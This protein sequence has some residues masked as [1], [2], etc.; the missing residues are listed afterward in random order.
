M[1]DE[2]DHRER[3]GISRRN[4][5]AA[6]GALGSVAAGG[7]AFAAGHDDHS[8]HGSQRPELSSALAACAATGEI[9]VAHCLASFKSGDTTLADCATKVHEMLAVCSAMSTL[10]AGNSSHT[11]GLATVCVAVCEDCSAACRKHA[12]EHRECAD[13]MKACDAVLPELKKLAA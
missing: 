1:S 10:V 9:C 13:C 4:L 2:R 7:S 12:K 3:A 5:L 6:A 8:A 11:R